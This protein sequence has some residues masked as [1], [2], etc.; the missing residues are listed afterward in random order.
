L[1][2]DG[3][4]ILPEKDIPSTIELDGGVLSTI[5][6]GSRVLEFACAWGRTAFELEK[7]GYRVTAFDIDPDIVD[8]ARKNAERIGSNVDLLVGDG[9]DLPFV[10]GSFDACIMNGFL[11]MLDGK[12]R[13]EAAIR[14]AWRVLVPGGYLY[15]ADFLQ[16]WSNP[17]YSDRYRTNYSVTGEMGTFLVTE[18]GSSEGKELYRAHHHTVDELLEL[19]ENN[20]RII[21]SSPDTFTSFHGNRV[22]GLKLLC[23]RSG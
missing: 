2:T 3:T 7:M 21:S 14:E 12:E 13:R 9:C 5:P 1:N 4:S 19:I 23:I 15:I 22:E 10:D 11:T 6:E 20:F 8:K 18:D 16:T 17:T